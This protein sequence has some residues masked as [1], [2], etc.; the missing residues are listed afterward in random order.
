MISFKISFPECFSSKYKIIGWISDKSLKSLNF[1]FFDSLS[2]NY[3]LKDTKIL[4][5]SFP[6]KI[7][8]YFKTIQL[9]T[10]ISKNI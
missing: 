9:L 5:S 2:K 7:L 4:I 8:F 6:L 10:K 1:Y 3:G